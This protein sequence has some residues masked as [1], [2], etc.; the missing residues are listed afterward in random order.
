MKKY[1]TIAAK[2][3]QQMKYIY[4]M[5]NKYISFTESYE[6]EDFTLADMEFVKDLYNDGE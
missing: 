2:S 4:A 5:R 1:T 6:F 3:Q